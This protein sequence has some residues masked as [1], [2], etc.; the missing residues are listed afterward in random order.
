MATSYPTGLDS[1]ANPASS[2]LLSA[3][4]GHAAQ[5]DNINDAVAALEAKVG[6]NSSAVTTSLDYKINHLSSGSIGR[7]VFPLVP[8]FATLPREIV[9]SSL[10][11]ANQNPTFYGFTAPLTG[12]F[13][14]VSLYLVSFDAATTNAVIS[15]FTVAANGDMTSVTGGLTGNI[16]SSLTS[17][18]GIK[19]VAFG[20]PVAFTA[21][22]AYAVC[23]WTLGGSPTIAATA[24]LGSPIVLSAI[25]QPFVLR[26]LAGQLT[27]PAGTV[28][29]SGTTGSAIGCPYFEFT[30]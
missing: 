29:Y 27:N 28:V 6:I 13:G 24:A 10:S 30:A 3:G 1:F 7:E 18:S 11:C 26:R 25:T 23:I 17:G 15:I 22:Q 9:T 2:D 4:T 12:T 20:T 21:G 16:S 19:T 8:A 5:H 14:H